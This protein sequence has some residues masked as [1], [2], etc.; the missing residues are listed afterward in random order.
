M[1]TSL[2][3]DIWETHQPLRVA[4]VIP[5]GH[6][7][8]VLRLPSGGLLAH[9]PVRLDDDLAAELTSLGELEIVIAPSHFHDSFLLPW[10][11]AYPEARFYCAPGMRTMIR[12]ATFTHKLETGSP[13][14]WTDVAEHVV[15]GGMPK[16]NETVFLHRPSRSLI[17]AD[18]VFNLA[19]AD[20]PPVTGQ[21]LRLFGTYDRF[22]VSR[23]LRA[24]ITDAAALRRDVDLVL[25]WDFE[26]VVVG[27]GRVLE[28][29]D[30]AAVD[31]L[32]RAWAWLN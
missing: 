15:I 2:G 30:G 25:S 24:M 8:T 31:A 21:L 28:G 20:L 16:V 32:R 4:G 11:S 22:A 1:L 9:S 19:A 10:F 5:L 17:V 3:P 18:F 6:R 12:G 13:E 26:R 27:H 14:P 23:L 29:A 7:M